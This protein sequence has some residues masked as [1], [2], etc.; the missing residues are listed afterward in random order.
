[1]PGLP[2]SHVAPRRAAVKHV[3]CRRSRARPDRTS[4]EG[5]HR[6][7]AGRVRVGRTRPNSHL[8]VPPRLLSGCRSA[9]SSQCRHAVKEAADWTR[10]FQ[11]AIILISPFSFQ[12]QKSHSGNLDTF[13]VAGGS[14]AWSPTL[15][16][17]QH[18]HSQTTPTA[19]Q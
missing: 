17:V 10:D 8:A 19:G 7:S 4:R 11:N 12:E 16:S 14:V 9:D 15:C 3:H 5:G 6:T 1:M 2:G 18:Q 13:R